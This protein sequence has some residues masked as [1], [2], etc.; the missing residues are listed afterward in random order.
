MTLDISV[1]SR[2]SGQLPQLENISQGLRLAYQFTFEFSETEHSQGGNTGPEA[3]HQV[4]TAHATK[5][6]G[7]HSSLLFFSEDV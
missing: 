6:T 4:A 2:F 7:L 5:T 1:E 3:L